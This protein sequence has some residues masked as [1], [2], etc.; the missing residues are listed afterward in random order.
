[1]IRVFALNLRAFF[2]ETAAS[3]MVQLKSH[4]ATDAYGRP[5]NPFNL[6]SNVL[7]DLLTQIYSQS[8]YIK[9]CFLRPEEPSVAG[10]ETQKK[11]RTEEEEKTNHALAALRLSED[12]QHIAGSLLDVIACSMPLLC[13]YA[14]MYFR[15]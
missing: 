15:E 4:K 3:Q 7:E 2:Y 9:H 6:C 12:A 11:T 14:H 10:P 8:M 5:I 1:M 13:M